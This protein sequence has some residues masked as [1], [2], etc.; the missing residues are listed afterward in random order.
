MKFFVCASQYVKM[1]LNNVRA[2]MCGFITF[3]YFSTLIGFYDL[4]WFNP[5]LRLIFI[6]EP[7]IHLNMCVEFIL[8]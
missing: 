7:F 6:K 5:Y 2:F 1:I 4:M 3:Q 8:E